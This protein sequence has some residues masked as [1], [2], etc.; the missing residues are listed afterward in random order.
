MEEG[1]ERASISRMATA[2]KQAIHVPIFSP[3]CGPTSE[4]GSDSEPSVGL[5][6]I[7]LYDSEHLEGRFKVQLPTGNGVGA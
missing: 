2:V 1:Y 4:V 3:T 6:E 5:L 7:Q